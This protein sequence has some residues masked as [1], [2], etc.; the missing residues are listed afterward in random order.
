[1]KN[2]EKNLDFFFF[3]SPP[4]CGAKYWFRALII[5]NV[6]HKQNAHLPFNG[7]QCLKNLF[8]SVKW[9]LILG[10]FQSENV[11]FNHFNIGNIMPIIQWC[12][13]GKRYVSICVNFL[14]G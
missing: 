13:S 7:S 6:G 1:M 10:K 12:T 11:Q 14:I 8:H 3:N 9:F 4:K 2:F 5:F